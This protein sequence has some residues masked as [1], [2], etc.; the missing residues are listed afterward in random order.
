MVLIINGPSLKQ[1]KIQAPIELLSNELILIRLIKNQTWRRIPITKGKE[2][3]SVKK[4]LNI[5]HPTCI[6]NRHIVQQQ[7]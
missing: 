3:F 2:A 7:I 1:F 4:Y 6:P 5:S